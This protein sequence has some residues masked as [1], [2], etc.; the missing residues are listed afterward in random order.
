MCSSLF[1]APALSLIVNLFVLFGFWLMNL[2]GSF[3]SKGSPVGYVRY[4]SPS[5]YANGLLHPR[6]AEFAVSGLAYVL[7]T[8][9]FL[10][11]AIVILRER[12]L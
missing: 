10:G 7:F 6:L 1:R 11:G 5:H 8:L 12:D 9:L 2:A 3:A 4:L